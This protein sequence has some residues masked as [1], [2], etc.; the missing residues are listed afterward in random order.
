[1]DTVLVYLLHG[2]GGR[3]LL[4]SRLASYLRRNNF[5]VRNWTYPSVREEIASNA[6]RLREEIE[7]A[8]L[9]GGF[10]RVDFVTHSLGGIVVRRLLSQ[11]SPVSIGRVVMLAPPNA[12]SH[13]ARFGSMFLR[14][15]C[16]VLREIS[17]RPT[18]FVEI[19]SEPSDVEI[20][21]I[22][23]S[24]DWVVRQASTHLP[25]ERDHIVLRGGHLSL[26]FL[27]SSV[28]QTEHFLRHGTFNH[29]STPRGAGRR[30]WRGKF[31][32]ARAAT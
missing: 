26:P 17:D 16:P 3:P 8:V 22:A 13:M 18:R 15:F 23:G 30:V 12:G 11:S 32:R 28:V 6:E 27:K 7:R 5:T 20:G 10:T 4:M 2:F 21:I 9:E 29:E 25:N 1:M 31:W 19:S 14:G 24:G